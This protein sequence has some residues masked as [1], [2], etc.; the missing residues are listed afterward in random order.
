MVDECLGLAD[1]CL[2]LADTCLWFT[3]KC[4]LFAD[5]CLWL[6]NKCNGWLMNVKFG[7]RMSRFCDV[8]ML[9]VKLIKSNGLKLM[10]LIA[11][12]YLVEIMLI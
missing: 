1:E 2:G 4:L 9:L 11:D 5:E 6:S 3:F 8:H 7:Y 10:T 12:E